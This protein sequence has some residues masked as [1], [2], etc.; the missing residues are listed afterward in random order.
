MPDELETVSP[1]A[2]PR[3]LLD[4]LTV[5]LVE[6]DPDCRDVLAFW[7]ESFGA[8]VIA[9]ASAHEALAQ[10]EGSL[11]DVV[12]TDIAMPDHNGFWLL[13]RVRQALAPRGVRVPVIACSGLDA[14]ASAAPGPLSGFDGYVTKPVDPAR[15]AACIAR[16]V[17]LSRAA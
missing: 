9:V 8:T 7:F 17:A 3:R 1:P 13:E 15:L 4:G 11:P 2:S 12:V 10:L 16:V 6:D 14:Y 5:L